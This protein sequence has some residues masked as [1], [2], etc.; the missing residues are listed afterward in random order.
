MDKSLLLFPPQKLEFESHSF[1]VKTR[2]L[3]S[4]QLQTFFLT[5]A[6]LKV[7]LGRSFLFCYK[8]G[9]VFLGKPW[10][11]AWLHFFFHQWHVSFLPPASCPRTMSSQVLLQMETTEE[12][13]IGWFHKIYLRNILMGLLMRH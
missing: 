1:P 3:L 2:K 7:T 13:K 5:I 4:P 6:V 10:E 8:A 9:A 12:T 11:H